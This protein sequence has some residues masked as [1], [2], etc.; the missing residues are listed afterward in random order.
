M[1]PEEYLAK[2]RDPKWY[3]EQNENGV[4]LSLIRENLRLT[5][6][7]E[8]RRNTWSMPA[9][10]PRSDSRRIAEVMLRHGVIGGVSGIAHA[11][12]V[13]MAQAVHAAACVAVR[14]LVRR[15][16]WNRRSIPA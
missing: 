9:C 10:K 16:L 11:N 15:L 6:G 12:R 14:L 1:T 8:A 5:R 2:T 4:D 13:P 3:G 7:A